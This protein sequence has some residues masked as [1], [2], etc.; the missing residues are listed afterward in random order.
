MSGS[1]KVENCV[2][3]VRGLVKT[4]NTPSVVKSGSANGAGS[5]NAGRGGCVGRGSCVS[6]VGRS[7][8][9][10]YGACLLAVWGI[11]F[12]TASCGKNSSIR[13]EKNGLKN[14]KLSVNVAMAAVEAFCDET[15]GFGTVIYRLKNDVTSLVNGTIREFSVKEGDFVKKGQVIARLKNVQLEI[16]RE[17]YLLNLESAKAAVELAEAEYAQAV[18]GVESRLL[19]VEKANLNLQRRE[20]EFELQKKNFETQR[21]L[22]EIGGVTKNSLEQQKISLESSG[23]EIE[24]LK[25]EIEISSLGLRRQDLEK[26]GVVPEEDEI[27]FRKQIVEFNTRTA[28]A[29]LMSA[30]AAYKNAE[31]QLSAVNTYIEE[32]CIKSPVAG[33]VG[34][35]YFETGEYLKENERIAVIFDT[36][37]VF[38]AAE[39]QEK[40]MVNLR[41]DAAVSVEFPSLDRSFSSKI[42]EIS[43]AADFQ[44]GNFSIKIPVEN[45]DGAL[46]PGMFA[47]CRIQKSLPEE[48]VCIPDQAFQGGQEED[49]KVFCVANGFAIQKD[50]RVKSRKNGKIWLEKGL[51]DGETVILNPAL[52]LKDGQAVQAAPYSENFAKK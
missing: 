2:G 3:S 1:V 49:G 8:L 44:S 40:D 39:I 46:K 20:I 16:Q 21:Q 35:K 5:A 18:L 43:P 50:V 12:F 6:C 23:A 13:G 48:Y 51:E 32:L 42:A 22:Y 29:S 31:Q 45:P 38:V 19:A 26:N 47:R 17:Q 37:S 30:K 14:E 11:L 15:E 27:L 52:F 41:E 7:S 34:E 25:K 24:I 28:F 9:K 33:I 10:K 36:E 4:A